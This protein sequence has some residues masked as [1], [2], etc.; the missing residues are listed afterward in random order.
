MRS[1]WCERHGRAA[2]RRACQGDELQLKLSPEIVVRRLSPCGCVPACKTSAKHGLLLG[3]RFE[4][5]ETSD[6]LG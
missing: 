4:R 2:H 3:R 6:G 1:L 5:S